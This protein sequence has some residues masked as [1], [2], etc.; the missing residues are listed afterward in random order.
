MT[1][2]QFDIA[3]AGGGLS[4]GLIAA[5]L[6]RYR[7][8]L[9]VVLVEAGETLGGGH[10]A[11]WFA[12]DLSPQ[13]VELLRPFRKTEWD[14]GYDVNFPA[15]RRTLATPCRSLSSDEFDAALHRQLPDDAIR[16]RRP[17]AALDG[18]G[19]TLADGERI[20]ARTVIDCRGFTPSPH[21]KGGWRVFMGRHLR[22]VRPHGIARPTVMDAAVEQHGTCRF[23]HVL[24]LAAHE[25]L[26]EESYYADTPT[27][28]RSLLSRR[29]DAYCAAR[30]WQGDIL[31]GEAGVLPVV[32]GGDFAAHQAAQRVE[33]VAIAGARGGFAHPLTGASLPLA[34]ETA[35]LVAAEGDLPGVQL[36]ALLE[37]RARLHWRRTRFYRRLA[38]VLFGSARP[39]QRWGVFA[40][41]YRLPEG[42]VERFHASRS[43]HADRARM[44]CGGPW[45]R[46]MAGWTGGGAA[47]AERAAA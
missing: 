11:S 27:P 38:R 16:I 33:D 24:P 23:V 6:A 36:S 35:L 22:T 28:D 31:G 44:L 42:L 43:T 25:L 32:T 29:I 8:E 19:M 30:G 1:G 47:L 39:D 37:T 5:A 17:I 12:S 14:H 26:V 46:A 2:R 13:G 18:S 40:R 7:P 9:R 20:A 34:V 21:L 10:R 45:M 41:I 4:G 3:I 15:W